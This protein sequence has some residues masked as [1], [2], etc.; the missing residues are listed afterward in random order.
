MQL[1]FGFEGHAPADVQLSGALSARHTEEPPHVDAR[2]RGKLVD[3]P[4]HA[5]QNGRPAIR[6]EGVDDPSGALLGAEPHGAKEEKRREEQMGRNSA[7][8]CYMTIC[9]ARIKLVG[10][11]ARQA[12]TRS[13]VC[14]AVPL[15]D[16]SFIQQPR[17][18]SVLSGSCCSAASGARRPQKVRVCV[19][20]RARSVCSFVLCDSVVARRVAARFG[21]GTRCGEQRACQNLRQSWLFP[22]WRKSHAWHSYA[23]RCTLHPT[24]H[25]NSGSPTL[26][27][28]TCARRLWPSSWKQRRC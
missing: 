6:A 25:W 3:D 5:H 8:V 15:F 21:R 9:R 14:R 26:V 10:P 27:V 22:C 23:S 2:A 16:R 7:L 17:S 1:G 13:H 12:A 19:C 24:R 20:A 11:A 18:R 4:S 28:R